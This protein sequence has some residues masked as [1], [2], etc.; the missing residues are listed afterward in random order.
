MSNADD[1][2]VRVTAEEMEILKNMRRTKA[3]REKNEKLLVEVL[4]TAAAYKKWLLLHNQ[5]DTYHV[6]C[7]EFNW[8]V[9]GWLWLPRAHFYALV[10]RVMD[11]ALEF[12]MEG[13]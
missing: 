10:V 3:A 5:V 1:M 2:L 8:K 12:V 13:E 9:D 6:F 7:D 11:C 4:D